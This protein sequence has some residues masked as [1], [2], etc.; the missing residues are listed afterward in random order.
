MVK[1]SFQQPAA[2]LKAE[3]DGTAACGAKA[4][5]FLPQDVVSEGFWREDLGVGAGFPPKD[6]TMGV[7]GRI[8][9]LAAPYALDKSHQINH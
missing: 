6:R 5:I 7:E 8:G 2:G 4:E 9:A 3:K 1:I